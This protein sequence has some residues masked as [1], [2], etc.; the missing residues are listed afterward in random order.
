MDRE[1]LKK[2]MTEQVQLLVDM[3]RCK[4]SRRQIMGKG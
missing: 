2:L 4:P 1:V 3:G